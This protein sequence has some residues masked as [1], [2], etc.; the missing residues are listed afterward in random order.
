M[1]ETYALPRPVNVDPGWIA[2]TIRVADPAANANVTISVSSFAWV[3]RVI[4]FSLT[5]DANAA[6]RIVQV[7][8]TTDDGFVFCR[9]GAGVLVTA[10]TSG[11]TF[12]GKASQGVSDFSSSGSDL[13]P[14]YFPLEP[15]RLEPGSQ[16]RIVVGNKQAADQLSAIALTVDRFTF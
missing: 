8:Y 9:N 14:V 4:V 6:N 13:T 12:C 10:S 7:T 5:T 2:D 1:S 15:L 16:V 3:P 11:L